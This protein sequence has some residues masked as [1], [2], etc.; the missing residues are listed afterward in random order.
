MKKILLSGVLS[1]AVLASCQKK[2]EETKPAEQPAEPP[3]QEQPAQQQQQE[4]KP[5]G[6]QQQ[7]QPA[8]EQKQEQKSQGAE[9]DMTA[10]AQ[11]K[12]K[13]M[14]QQKAGEQKQ[15]QPAQVAAKDMTALAQQKGCYACHAND[16][17]KVGPAFKDVA[18]KYAG[19]ADAIDYLAKKIKNGGAGV[20]GQVP[21]PP[22]NVTDQEAKELA[23]WILSLK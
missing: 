8:G 16:A 22:Q 9:K 13:P 5:A 11:Q 2:A 21:M 23:E 20:W 14:E 3:A 19:Q 4:Q 18:K 1:L 17:K 10:S 12:Q 15:Q 6:E 7:Q